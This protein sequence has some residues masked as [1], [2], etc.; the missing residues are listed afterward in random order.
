MYIKIA[1]RSSC[2]GREPST[3][4]DSSALNSGFGSVSLVLTYLPSSSAAR[5]SLSTPK[6]LKSTVH[7]PRHSLAEQLVCPSPTA[8]IVG[9]LHC[10]FAVAGI[11]MSVT[12]SPG[13]QGS[14]FCILVLPG[15]FVRLRNRI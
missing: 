7:L 11:D 14:S 1:S 10:N 3:R 12:T 15:G 8:E 9:Q 2:R 13:K 6:R 5:F 4:K